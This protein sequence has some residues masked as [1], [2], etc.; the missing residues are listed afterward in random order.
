MA[1]IPLN[2]LMN[3]KP[4]SANPGLVRLLFVFLGR[5]LGTVTSVIGS[6]PC[7]NESATCRSLILT[8]VAS[9]RNLPMNKI[10]SRPSR[11]GHG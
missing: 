3:S 11:G 8:K 6:N 2:Y 5:A 4:S 7:G 1:S 10:T 9:W